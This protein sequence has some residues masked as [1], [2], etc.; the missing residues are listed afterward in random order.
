MLRRVIPVIFVA[1]WGLYHERRSVRG[2]YIQ[3]RLRVT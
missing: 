3:G 1:A 2:P